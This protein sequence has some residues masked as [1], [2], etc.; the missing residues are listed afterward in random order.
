MPSPVP[1]PRRLPAAHSLLALT[2][3]SWFF[4]TQLTRLILLAVFSN[5]PRPASVSPQLPGRTCVLVPL[6]HALSWVGSRCRSIF[7]AWGG[8]GRHGGDTRTRMDGWRW[9]EDGRTVPTHPI[10]CPQPTL[11]PRSPSQVPQLCPSGWAGLWLSLALSEGV[12]NG[13]VLYRLPSRGR[14]CVVSPFL[15]GRTPFRTVSL[16][17]PTEKPVLM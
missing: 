10:S 4:K 15:L 2:D 14:R 11:C 13:R 5:P 7:L 16:S 1:A 17:L 6:A 3:S 8:P 9:V 12:E